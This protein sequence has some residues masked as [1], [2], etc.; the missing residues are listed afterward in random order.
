[1][2]KQSEKEREREREQRETEEKSVQESVVQFP[3]A[4]SHTHL[5]TQRP[6]NTRSNIKA[7]YAAAAP[8]RG[9]YVARRLRRAE[10][11]SP[12]RPPYVPPTSPLR[13]PYVPPTPPPPSEEHGPLQRDQSNGPKRGGRGFTADGNGFSPRSAHALKFKNKR[14]H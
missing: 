11:T 14:A 6:A 10:A 2:E 5:L 9:G 7:S 13:P 1:M 4:S 12:L 8:Q 3:R